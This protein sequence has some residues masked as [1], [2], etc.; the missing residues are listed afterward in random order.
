MLSTPIKYNRLA[1]YLG[2]QNLPDALLGIES[3]FE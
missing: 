2:L 3:A 1:G